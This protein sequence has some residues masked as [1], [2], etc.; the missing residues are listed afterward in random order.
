MNS[1]WISALLLALSVITGPALAQG[2]DQLA[3]QALKN[4]LV[5]TPRVFTGTIV[6]IEP[7]TRTLTLRGTKGNV[8]PVV[9]QKQVSNFD[10]LKIGDR[11]DVMIKNALLLK[12]VKVS[13]KD[14]GIRERVDTKV[15]APASDGSSYGAVHQV[16]IL[17]TVERIDK[18]HKTITLR[19][20]QRTGSFDLSPAIAAQNLKVGDTVHAVYISALAVEVTPKQQ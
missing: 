11:V 14:D 12:A 2:D 17:A 9:V 20:A 10:S 8:V 7:G 6:G 19:G 13:A 3:S 1:K 18:K 16:E 4:A 5:A 15:Y